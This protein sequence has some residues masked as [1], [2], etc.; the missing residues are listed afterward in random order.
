MFTDHSNCP[1]RIAYTY[2]NCA[3]GFTQIV[4]VFTDG[5]VEVI[6]FAGLSMPVVT[7]AS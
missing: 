5:K 2:R 6:G 3:N 4:T 1:N 7:I